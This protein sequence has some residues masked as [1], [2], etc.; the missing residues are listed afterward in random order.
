M[1]TYNLGM[2]RVCGRKISNA[3]FA[4]AAH[5]KMHGREGTALSRHGNLWVTGPS[6]ALYLPWKLG[7]AVESGEIGLDKATRQANAGRTE[8]CHE[9]E[10]R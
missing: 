4:V 9:R 1:K 3:G 10:T 5:M 8:P 6:R 7:R 2:C